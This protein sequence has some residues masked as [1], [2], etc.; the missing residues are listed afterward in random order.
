VGEPTGG[1]PNGYSEHGEFTLSNSKL[2]VNYSSRYYKFQDKDTPAVMPDKIIEPR[3][4]AY[5]AGEDPVMAWIVEQPKP[6]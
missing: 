2:V 5:R 1:R 6:E 3:W 4:D